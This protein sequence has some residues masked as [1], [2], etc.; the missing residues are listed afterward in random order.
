[1]FL[2]T[3]PQTSTAPSPDVDDLIFMGQSGPIVSQR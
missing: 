2:H 1:M 3:T